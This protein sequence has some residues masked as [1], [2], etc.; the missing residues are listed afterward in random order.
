MQLPDALILPTER[1][2]SSLDIK[3]ALLTFERVHLMS[4]DD[5]ELVA[6]HA[7]LTATMPMP[8][9]FAFGGGAVLPLGKFPD[10]DRQFQITLEECSAAERAGLV[11]L[12]SN[13][14]LMSGGA[15][16]GT[17]P[18]PPDWPHPTF[19]VSHFHALL[20][21]KETLLALLAGLPGA[22]QLERRSV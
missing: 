4:P 15:S 8:M 3:R 17:V 11:V 13:P 18:N 6:P 22:D 10:H 16:I 1:P 5:R 12:R 9:P 19:I 20:R 14:T 21:D 2:V 7:Y